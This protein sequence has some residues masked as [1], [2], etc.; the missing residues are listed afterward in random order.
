[1]MPL[2]EMGALNCPLPLIVPELATLAPLYTALG[3]CKS[4]NPILG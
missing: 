3:P 4:I 1:M 2:L